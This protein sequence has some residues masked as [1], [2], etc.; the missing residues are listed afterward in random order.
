MDHD[1][2][3]PEPWER[4]P[5]ESN[6]WYDRFEAYRL[7]GARRSLLGAVNAERRRRNAPPGRSVPQAWAKNAK[8][9]RWLERAEAWDACQRAEGRRARAEGFEEMNRRHVQEAQALQGKAV[10]RLKSLDVER[11]SPADVLR[12][13]VEAAKLERTALGE[14][15]NVEDPRR[16]GRDGGSAAFTLEDAVRADQELEEQRRAHL[17]QPGSPPPSEG[18]IQVP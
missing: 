10:Q 7:A 6:L 3:P 4:Q 17:Q 14:P 5:G 12:F 1:L 13:C 15:E 9:W 16:V 11:M 18:S 8:R 2:P